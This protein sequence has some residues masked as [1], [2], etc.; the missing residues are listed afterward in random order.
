MEL[1]AAVPA[2][3]DGVNW[4]IRSYARRGT[5]LNARQ[6]ES[7]DRH[8][9]RWVVA[10]ETQTAPGFR[11]PDV[12]ERPGPLIIEIGLGVGEALVSLATSRPEANVLGFEVWAPGVAQC[13]NGLSRTDARNVR[14]STLDAAWCLDNLLEPASITEL[15]TFF[16]DPWPKARHH[17]RRLV[18]RRFAALAA[19]R[20]VPGGS[21]RLATDWPDYADQMREVLDS[22]PLLRGGVTERFADRPLT[23]FERRGLAAGRSIVDLTYTRPAEAASPESQALSAQAYSDRNCSMATR[24]PPCSLADS[25][26]HS[27]S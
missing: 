18:N 24:L 14:L 22:E 12:F 27:A 6:Q 25:S 1:T 20:L 15:W 17:K 8:A 16:P 13:L 3:P 4:E 10:P 7:W 26:K 2:R 11:L 23:R 21:W 19:S 5:R 9:T